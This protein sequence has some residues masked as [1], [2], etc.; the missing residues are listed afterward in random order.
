MSER[1][2][3]ATFV[4]GDTTNAFQLL[5]GPKDQRAVFQGNNLVYVTA[6]PK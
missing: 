2:E 4:L 5:I 6:Q 1:M 3:S